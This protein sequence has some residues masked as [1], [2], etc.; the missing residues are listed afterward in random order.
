MVK[1]RMA[2]WKYVKSSIYLSI[3]IYV[4]FFLNYFS[5]SGWKSGGGWSSGGSA[6]PSSSSSSGKIFHVN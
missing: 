1:R 6:W 3:R 5:D 2:K 4:M